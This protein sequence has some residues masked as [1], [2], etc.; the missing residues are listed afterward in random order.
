MQCQRNGSYIRQSDRQAD[1]HRDGRKT[2]QIGIHGWVV[3]CHPGV[4]PRGLENA[5][6]LGHA[7]TFFV[8]K[9]IGEC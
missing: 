7:S 4:L 1:G 9:K 5:E 8:T 3:V 6:R 2:R